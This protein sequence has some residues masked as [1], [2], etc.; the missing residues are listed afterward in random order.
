MCDVLLEARLAAD[1]MAMPAGLHTKMRSTAELS[2]GRSNR[3]HEL[4]AF[5]TRPLDVQNA[6]TKGCKPIFRSYRSHLRT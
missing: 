4:T 5:R 3:M 2:R 1:R 6:P